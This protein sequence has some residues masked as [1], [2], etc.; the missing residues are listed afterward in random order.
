MGKIVHIA[1]IECPV[2]DFLRNEIYLQTVTANATA[3]ATRTIEIEF[4]D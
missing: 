4:T 1:K 2:V 3:V